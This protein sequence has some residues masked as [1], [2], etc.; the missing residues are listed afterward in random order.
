M[1]DENSASVPR[2]MFYCSLICRLCIIYANIFEH[3]V[4]DFGAVFYLALVYTEI[5]SIYY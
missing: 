5:S 1:T 4:L 3:G 2:D